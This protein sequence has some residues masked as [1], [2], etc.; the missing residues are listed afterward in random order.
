MNELVEMSINLH[1]FFVVLS[2]ILSLINIFVVKKIEDYV[3]MTKK[4]ELFTPA[5]YLSLSITVFTGFIVLSVYH[6][7]FTFA[8]YIMIA[9]TIHIIISGFKCH[10][11]F[12]KTRMQDKESQITFRKFADRKYKIDSILIILTIILAFVFKT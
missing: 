6:F 11:F 7:H 8:V 3:D 4:V 10:K 2:L 5:Y 9:S 1:L 12:K